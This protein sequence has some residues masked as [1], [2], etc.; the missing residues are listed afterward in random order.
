[1]NEKSWEKLRQE[2]PELG[3]LRWP[4]L[5]F[6]DERKAGRMTRQ[7]VIAEVTGRALQGDPHEFTIDVPF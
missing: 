5:G 1:M 2:R 6:T 3:L 7:Q 4:E